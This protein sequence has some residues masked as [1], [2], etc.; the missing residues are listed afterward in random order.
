MRFYTMV[1]VNRVMHADFASNLFVNPSY[2]L[3]R[4]AGGN[5]VPRHISTEHN[6]V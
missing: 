4:K 2:V 3:L 1:H 6:L 5:I